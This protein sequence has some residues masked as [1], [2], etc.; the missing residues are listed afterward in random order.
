VTDQGARAS[1]QPP[2]NIARGYTG[3]LKRHGLD[4]LGDRDGGHVELDL[5][6][7]RKTYKSRHYLRTAG[8]LDDFAVGHTKQVAARHYADIDA[9]RDL[10]EQAVEAGLH[11]ALTVALAPPVVLDATGARLDDGPGPLEPEAVRV[12]LS[13]HNDVWLASC[14][15]FY[16]SPFA[17]K[18]GTGCPVAAWGCLECPNAVFTTRHLPS[19]LSFR[20]FLEGQRDELSTVEWNARYGLAHQRIT[21]GVL[22]RFTEQ[23]LSIA[24]AIAESH[25]PGLSLPAQLLE[26]VS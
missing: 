26:H 15:D 4:Q 8:V 3:W 9:H 18:P 2:R 1:F 13:G 14:K 25:E 7:L 6:R 23:Q 16:A 11:E 21:S 22:P 5:R 20:S 12:A 24:Q 17:V 19:L 10:H